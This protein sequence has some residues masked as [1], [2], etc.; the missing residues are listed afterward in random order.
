MSVRWR[1]E[2]SDVN[3]TNFLGTEDT[4]GLFPAGSMM[5]KLNKEIM[6]SVLVEDT[7]TKY[8]DKFIHVNMGKAPVVVQIKDLNDPRRARWQ[9]LGEYDKLPAVHPTDYKGFAIAVEE[10]GIQTPYTLRMELFTEGIDYPKE[11]QEYLS[12][13]ITV[14]KNFDIMRAMLYMD[15]LAV[16]NNPTNPQV[17]FVTGKSLLKT[18]TFSNA[19]AGSSFVPSVTVTQA[20]INPTTNQ[21]EGKTLAPFSYKALSQIVFHLIDKRWVRSPRGGYKNYTIICNPKAYARLIDDPDLKPLYVYSK[22][23]VITEGV[24]IDLL[25]NT[26]VREEEYIKLVL[27]DQNEVG[28]SAIANFLLEKSVAI[29]LGDQAVA[30]AVTLPETVKTEK[31]DFDR[32]TSLG[33]YTFRN[34]SPIWFKSQE[35]RGSGVVIIAD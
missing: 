2:G 17:D 23:E 13:I 11:A 25:G 6:R 22:P 9:T 26:I 32:F 29:I 27:G 5:A 16:V 4:G 14:N 33:V 24:M 8:T 10:R 20:N 15:I 34:E 21:V 30:E 28:T 1:I 19:Y 3:Q 18:K 7:L 31:A 12:N 35:P